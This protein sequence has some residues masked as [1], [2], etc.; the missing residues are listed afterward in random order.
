VLLQSGA[1]GNVISYNYSLNP[2][3]S[4]SPPANGAGDLVLHGNYPFAN[5]FEGNI[6]QNVMID[7]SHG[8]NGP[9][10]TF[11]RNRVQL[12]GIIMSPSPA[13]DSMNS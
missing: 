7:A 12:Y 13:T 8:I 5:L 9:Y 10:N 11:F 2:N 3:Q 1:N 6:C 4:D